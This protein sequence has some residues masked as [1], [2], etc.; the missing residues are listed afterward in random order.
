MPFD[1]PSSAELKQG[2][3]L[4]R[5]ALIPGRETRKPHDVGEPDCSKAVGRTR[6]HNDFGHATFNLVCLRVEFNAAIGWVEDVGYPMSMV[7]REPLAA[8]PRYS[9]RPLPLYR[10]VPGET[11][12]PTPGL[13]SGAG[14]GATGWRPEE[15]RAIEA[16]LWAVDLFNH[17]YWWECHEA[18]ESLWHAA[19]RTTP[20]ARFVQSLVHLSAA[21]LNDRRG[22]TRAA[23]RQAA[24]AVR[25]LRAARAMGAVV[26][27]VELDGLA[28]A[29][30]LAFTG[31]GPSPAGLRIELSMSES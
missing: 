3:E 21:C 1:D 29:V 22:H 8:L 12:R 24:R 6:G 4:H 31:H 9:S 19:G 5:R 11:P 23:R 15:W 17:G 10:F 27:G 14:G 16:W 30:V 7:D 28:E 2:H 18:L 25:G 13:A 26:M 20:P